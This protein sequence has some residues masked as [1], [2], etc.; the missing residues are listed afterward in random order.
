MR[1][2]NDFIEITGKINNKKFLINKTNIIYVT[3]PEDN[4]D[5]Q[6]V[7]LV[8]DGDRSMRIISKESYKD[9]VEELLWE[10]REFPVYPVIPNTNE[11]IGNSIVG[12]I[13][14]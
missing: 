4:S 10:P 2:N 1:S 14:E 13:K 5:D 7:I 12:E 9:V 6:A 11:C 3:K 8:K